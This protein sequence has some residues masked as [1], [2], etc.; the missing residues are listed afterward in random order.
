MQLKSLV[1]FL[2]YST[3][4]FFT[5]LLDLALLYFLSD[6]VLVNYVVAA[7]I[8]FVI[9]ISVNHSLSRKH[10]FKGTVRTWKI[11]YVNFLLIALIGLLI[12]TGGMYVLVGLLRV[13]FLAAR[14]SIAIIT[15]LWNYTV[16]L[17]A[18]FKV[19]GKH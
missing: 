4:G 12:V 15:G 14:I 11:G 1:R 10:V 5:F 19:A 13:N 7:G 9:A 18:N 2:K 16:N 17:F 6:I 3:I 8:A